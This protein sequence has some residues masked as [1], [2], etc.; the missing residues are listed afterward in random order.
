MLIII[1]IIIIIIIPDQPAHAVGVFLASLS[2]I[3]DSVLGSK[4][5]LLP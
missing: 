3:I 2:D 4:D 5:F 1:I